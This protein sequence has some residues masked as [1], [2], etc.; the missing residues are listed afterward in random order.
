MQFLPPATRSTKLTMRFP[1]LLTLLA[2]ICLAIFI[3]PGA[4][5]KFGDINA[6]ALLKKENQLPNW[7][8]PGKP[9][10]S[11]VQADIAQTADKFAKEDTNRL[12]AFPGVA[13]PVD[14]PSFDDFFRRLQDLESLSYEP[15]KARGI[16]AFGS[17][18]LPIV[19]QPEDNSLY[20]SNHNGILTQFQSALRYGI[21][22]LLAH[23]YLSGRE[24]YNL[25][26]GQEIQVI[27]GD[28][29]VQSYRISEIQR[30]QKMIPSSPQSRYI[31][32]DTGK[33]MTT[34]EVF[35]KF[36]RGSNQV[37]FQTCL[38]GDGLLNWGLYFVVAQPID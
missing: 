4:S 29:R 35:R 12:T 32:L 21:T 38:E 15:Q 20:V 10:G 34:K 33:E 11:L 19:Q 37:T 23:N 1:K 26:L 18:A 13:E 9:I 24:F 27:Y 7:T 36:Y 25:G 28:G 6:P 3:L 16:Y 30:Y 31:E 2:F 17:F 5:N 14:F 8:L 22:G